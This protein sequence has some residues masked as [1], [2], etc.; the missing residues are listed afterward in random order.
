MG[1]GEARRSV[2]AIDTFRILVN[3]KS[4]LSIRNCLLGQSCVQPGQDVCRNSHRRGVLAQPRHK[5]LRNRLRFIDS[6]DVSLS[7]ELR[8]HSYKHTAKL[9]DSNRKWE[10]LE[11]FMTV[12][13]AQMCTY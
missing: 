1:P 11:A 8:P 12:R 13:G 10:R 7:E 5:G 6:L 3:L 2:N 9:Q 4:S